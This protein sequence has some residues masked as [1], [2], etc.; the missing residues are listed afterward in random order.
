MPCSCMS[1]IS[2]SSFIFVS[3]VVSIVLTIEL[4]ETGTLALTLAFLS[5]PS[6]TSFGELY[7]SYCESFFV[8]PKQYGDSEGFED[9]PIGSGNIIESRVCG[10]GKLNERLESDDGY[11][12]C[13][14][15]TGNQHR[16]MRMRQARN[17]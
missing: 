5:T 16:C 15:H 13:T 10:C 9:G 3:N 6:D 7:C 17:A 2:S 14:N 8:V 12:G 11:D 4:F 1:S